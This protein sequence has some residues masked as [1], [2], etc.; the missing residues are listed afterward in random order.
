MIFDGE[1][2]LVWFHPLPVGT[3]AAN[4]Q[5]QRYEEKPVLSWWQGYIPRRGSARGRGGGGL[6]LPHADA[7]PRRQRLQADLHDFHLTPQGTAL[8][9]RSTR[10]PATSPRVK[11]AGNGAVTDGVFQ[12]LDLK[13][14][15]VRREWHT[16]D[17][18]ALPPYSRPTTSR[19][20]RS[21]TSTSTRCSSSGDGFLLISARNT[22]AL[23]VLDPATGRMTLQTG[24]KSGT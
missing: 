4:L 5:V 20:G 6:L 9:T 7:L 19:R 22:S 1:G 2:R 14:K 8:L 17:H 3:Y 18:V 15:L 12:E 16:L 11:A 21:T 23:Y 24:G 13:T 10:S